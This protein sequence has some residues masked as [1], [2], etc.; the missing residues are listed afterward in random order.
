VD[1]C[2]V[3][4]GLS[5][6]L[7]WASLV[8]FLKICLVL[9]GR[10]KRRTLRGGQAM[11]LVWAREWVSAALLVSTY[12]ILI[13]MSLFKY[14]DAN[15]SCKLVLTQP[16]TQ[17]SPSSA[18]HPPPPPLRPRFLLPAILLRRSPR[19]LSGNNGGQLEQKIWKQC[20]SKGKLGCSGRKKAKRALTPS[21]AA[22]VR[23][24]PLCTQN[25]IIQIINAGS[26][27]WKSPIR[28]ERPGMG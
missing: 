18:P 4:L 9:L 24:R 11:E 7:L 15:P 1:C 22:T 14:Y 28:A 6:M 13:Q 12:F 19:F 17:V 8:L 16:W 3:S 26:V 27:V 5:L 25:T 10:A 20:R 2:S 21:K 23:T